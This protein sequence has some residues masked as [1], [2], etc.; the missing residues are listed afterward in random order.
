MWAF[1]HNIV[2]PLICQSKM[3]AY[4]DVY[5]SDKYLMMLGFILAMTYSDKDQCAG[6]PH[7]VLPL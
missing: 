4:K 5:H 2:C 7:F 3:K 1:L 6:V